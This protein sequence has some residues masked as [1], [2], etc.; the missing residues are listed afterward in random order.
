MYIFLIWYSIKYIYDQC[1]SQSLPEFAAKLKECRFCGPFSA[2]EIE[3]F[4][5]KILNET[6]NELFLNYKKTN[7]EE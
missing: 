5:F 4:L 1:S 6:L 7:K 3:N 2:L